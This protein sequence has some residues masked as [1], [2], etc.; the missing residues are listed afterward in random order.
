MPPSY[1]SLHSL[2]VSQSF[3]CFAS[4][5]SG[6]VNG[7]REHRMPFRPTKGVYGA[8]AIRLLRSA[9]QP[10][11]RFSFIRYGTKPYQQPQM[12]LS[13][14]FK[15]RNKS[16][17]RKRNILKTFHRM[18]QFLSES[19]CLLPSLC[20]MLVSTCLLRNIEGGFLFFPLS[21]HHVSV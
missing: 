18:Q 2:P 19:E 15:S 14:R 20:C 21:F 17:R 11:A 4:V 7:Q 9:A 10:L 12:F 6:L 1:Y 8:T 16:L 13:I 5:V 3:L